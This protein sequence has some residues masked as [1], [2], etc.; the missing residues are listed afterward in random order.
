[1]KT[2]FA[3]LLVGAAVVV[4]GEVAPQKDAATQ[5]QLVASQ[6]ATAAPAAQNPAIDYAGFEKIAAETAPVREKRRL[7][8]KE[9]AAMAAQPGTVV[10]DARSADKF[11]MRHI[12]GAV[13]LPFTEFTEATLAKVLPAKDTRVLIYCNNNFNGAPRSM[14]RKAADPVDFAD[15]A[16]VQRPQQV[17][18][19]QDGRPNGAASLNINSYIALATYG[20]KNVYELGPLLNVQSTMLPFEGSEVPVKANSATR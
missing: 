13:N 15:R 17:Q 2:T 1:M 7:T 6:K 4:A 14:A 12:S 20:Y 8:E 11:A 16:Q 3:F 5:S 19:P 18:V 10:L 9:F